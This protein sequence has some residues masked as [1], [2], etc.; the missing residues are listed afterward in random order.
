[1]S[2]LPNPF[3]APQTASAPD[4]NVWGDTPPEALL[5]V[6]TGLSMVYFSICGMLLLA[7][8]IPAILFS[9]GDNL[10][11]N[12]L[13]LLGLLLGGGFLLLVLL[14]LA[15][16][17]F[18]L[19]VPPETG[20][21]SLVT[22]SLVLQ[23]ISVFGSVAGLVLNL[24][25]IGDSVWKIVMMGLSLASVVCFLLFMRRVALHI[26]RGDV[27]GRAMRA[28]IMG[29]IATVTY[30]TAVVL[31]LLGVRQLGDPMGISG[32]LAF[33]GAILMLISLIMYANTVTYLRKA[34]VV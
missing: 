19:A 33:V 3:A 32:I 28:L 7:L 5:K 8:L 24:P 29:I 26:H 20:A 9:L 6:K 15:G 14:G 13:G 25:L 23:G 2:D 31:A 30:A 11:P 22:A 10:D 27:A 12:S 1:M 16:Q 18:C 4:E 21:R 17:G 34:I